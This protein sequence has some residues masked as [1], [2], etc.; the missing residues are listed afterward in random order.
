MRSEAPR[1][2]PRGIKHGVRRASFNIRETIHVGSR[3]VADARQRHDEHTRGPQMRRI[4][5]PFWP[6]KAVAAIVE[7]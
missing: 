7:R 2:P 4:A 1:R 5:K 6:E 3:V